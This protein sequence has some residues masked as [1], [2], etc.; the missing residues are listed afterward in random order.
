MPKC[1]CRPRP[2]RGRSADS[3]EVL[4][5]DGE[6]FPVKRR[7]LRPC[8]ALTHAVRG[9]TPSVGVDVD[10]LVFDRSAAPPGRKEGMAHIYPAARAD[11]DEV[12]APSG[13]PLPAHPHR[14]ACSP[15]H[16]WTRL[17]PHHTCA[18]PS[19]RSCPQACSKGQRQKYMTVLV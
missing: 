12:D 5:R 15:E 8:I 7:L 2:A 14:P 6:A 10:T 18:A 11:E 19:V 13:A 16:W 9:E 4:T 3:L 1:C 17:S